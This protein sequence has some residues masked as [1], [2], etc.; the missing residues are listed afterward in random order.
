MLRATKSYKFTFICYN[1]I[2]INEFDIIAL[3]EVSKQ[4]QGDCSSKQSLE[5][6][7]QINK[8]IIER[9]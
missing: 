8:H 3:I 1:L 2:Y 4:S 5:L 7:P 6:E 9:Y